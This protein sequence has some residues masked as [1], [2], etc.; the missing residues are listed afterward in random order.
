MI[1]ER[2][3]KEPD[4]FSFERQGTTVICDGSSIV[5]GEDI[6]CFFAYF[7]AYD[8]ESRDNYLECLE[9]IARESIFERVLAR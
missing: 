7:I 8:E 4:V 2:Q 3:V 1:I 5:Q 6:G 9:E